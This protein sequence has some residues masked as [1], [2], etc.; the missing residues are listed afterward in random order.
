M[1]SSPAIDTVPE[2]GFSSPAITRKSVDFPP[3]LGPSSAV[4]EPSRTSSDTS[5]SAVKSP[6]RLDTESMTMLMSVL[7]LA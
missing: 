7:P 5:S 4:S 6:K 3:P 1:A 2:S